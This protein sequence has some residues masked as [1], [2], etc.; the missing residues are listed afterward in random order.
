MCKNFLRS[1]LIFIALFSVNF[2]DANAASKESVIGLTDNIHTN[3][4][5]KCS[6]PQHEVK[7]SK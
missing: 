2:N 1:L 5:S 7:V 6:A 3:F 4:D